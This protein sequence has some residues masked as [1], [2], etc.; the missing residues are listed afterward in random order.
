MGARTTVLQTAAIRVK[1]EFA[2]LRFCLQ[3][4]H[5][6]FHSRILLGLCDAQL[7]ISLKLILAFERRRL[8]PVDALQISPVRLTQVHFLLVGHLFM[9]KVIVV[10]ELVLYLSGIKFVHLLFL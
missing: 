7:N 5:A 2:S 4:A 8:L 10:V 3:Y 6:R 9:S 1:H